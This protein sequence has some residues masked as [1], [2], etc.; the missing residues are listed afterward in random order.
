MDDAPSEGGAKDDQKNG[1]D[2]QKNG[3]LQMQVC[4]SGKPL[5]FQLLSVENEHY[6][7]GTW[8]PGTELVCEPSGPDVTGVAW[9]NLDNVLDVFVTMASGSVASA[10]GDIQ[11]E[12]HA[13]STDVESG[14]VAR[15]IGSQ[16][17][18]PRSG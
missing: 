13:E 4:R 5:F 9:Q 17:P 7:G 1:S 16:K 14:T 3:S 12:L 6:L 11:K 18:A 10:L 15:L 8:P 2:N